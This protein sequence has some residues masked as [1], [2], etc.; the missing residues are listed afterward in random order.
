MA[1]LMMLRLEGALQSWGEASAWDN[2]GTE[3]F[4]AKSAIA[5]LIACAMGLER[6][7]PEIL[8]LQQSITMGIR[9][10]RPG[11]AVCDFHTVQGMPNILNAAG[12]GRGK[13]GNTIVSH[14]WYL[15]DASFLVVIETT[16]IWRQ[17]IVTALQDPRWPVYLGRK[18]CVP[19]RPVLEGISGDYET[20]LQALRRYP[21]ET[22]AADLL[23]YEIETEQMDGTSLSRTDLSEGNRK[24]MRRKVWRGTVRR[25][26]L[27]TLQN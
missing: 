18:N 14:R 12:K 5:G 10:D 7:D 17:R 25:E 9:A 23:P 19:S 24:F 20:I 3:N 26:E 4:P 13:N 6:G 2:R 27:C 11:Q 15:Q 16:D 1:E 22:R 8:Q 21:A